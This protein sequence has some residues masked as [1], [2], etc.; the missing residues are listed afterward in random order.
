MIAEKHALERQLNSLEVELEAEKRSKQRAQK[1]ETET[2]ELR[3]SIQELEKKLAAEKRS[4]QRVIKEDKD[5]NEELQ[6]RVDELEKK[7]AAEKKDKDRVRKEGER[8]LSEATAQHEVFEERL[9]TMKAKL[10]EA[11]DEL[12][13]CH[14]ELAEARNSS[15]MSA[16]ISERTVTLPAARKQMK[17][18]RPEEVAA[19][20]TILTPHAEEQK[21]KR[22]FKKRGL[23]FA[24][25]GEKSTFSITPFLNRTKALDDSTED[26][27]ADESYVPEPKGTVPSPANAEEPS[28]PNVDAEAESA[29]PEPAAKPAKARGRPRKV[30]GE[31]S[32]ANTTKRPRAKADDKNKATKQDSI[33]EKVDEEPIQDAENVA[34]SPASEKEP[35]NEEAAAEKPKPAKKAPVR[36]LKPSAKQ[37]AEDAAAA[38]FAEP[39]PKKK[40]RKLLG[41][42]NKTLFD[43]DEGDVP[44]KPAPAGKVALGGARKLGA[45]GALGVKRDAFAGKTFSPLKRDRR[46]VH[47]SFLA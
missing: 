9:G 3:V 28:Q 42:P 47:A 7:L 40:K 22:A 35:E 37:S 14:A 10:R 11:R 2:D 29:A 4:N 44:A 15:M 19:E 13:R 27:E 24:G 8:A 25:M 21:V 6:G 39:E 5:A 30:L 34:P 16:D 1:D 31:I 45:G 23:D 38:V 43:D 36:K 20:V 17:K 12:K 26:V 46:G 18:R 33:L 41:G 32:T